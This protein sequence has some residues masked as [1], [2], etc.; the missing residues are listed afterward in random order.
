[1]ADPSSV[2]LDRCSAL[3][4]GGRKFDSLDELLADGQADAVLIASPTGEHGWQAQ[5]VLAAGKAIYLEKPISSSLDEGTR[6]VLAAAQ[7]TVPAMMGFNYRFHPLVQRA[8]RAIEN[9]QLTRIRQVRSCFSIAARPLPAWKQERASGGGVLLDLAS[10]HFYL[11][12]YLLG[13]PVVTVTARIWSERSEDDCCQAE[14]TFENGVRADCFYS[15]CRHEQD[16][17]ELTAENGRI[18]VDR[19][20]PLRYPMWPAADFMAYQSER[21]HSPWKEVSFRRSLSSW[22]QAV[23]GC[24]KAPITMADGFEVLQVVLAAEQSAL[25]GTP[26]EVAAVSYFV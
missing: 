6:V 18:S 13:V 1:V 26:V 7:A 23:R 21:L 9:K 2:A 5:R 24:D 4:E 20:A 17:L 11:M 22:I 14:L 16:K 25:C 3:S 8:K 10:H 12:L 15:F 19:Y